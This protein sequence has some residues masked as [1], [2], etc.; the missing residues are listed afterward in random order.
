LKS[1]PCMKFKVILLKDEWFI[2]ERQCVETV[3]CS[4]YI[5]IKLSMTWYFC[6]N[7]KSGLWFIA[8]PG[9]ILPQY[10]E[11]AILFRNHVI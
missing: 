11:A 9:Q 6:G 10:K 1:G 7:L 8:I 3:I 4:H 5:N 2:C